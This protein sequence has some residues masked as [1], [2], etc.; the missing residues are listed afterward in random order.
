[1]ELGYLYCNCISPVLKFL[2][3]N[4]VKS[5]VTDSTADADENVLGCSKKKML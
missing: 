1:M 5:F 2:E 4:E 3:K